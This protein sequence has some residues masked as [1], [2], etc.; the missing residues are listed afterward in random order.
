MRKQYI[1]SGNKKFYQELS[2]KSKKIGKVMNFRQN[3]WSKPHIGLNTEV[4]SEAENKIQENVS[5]S[6][7][8]NLS[9]EFE[10]DG[11][12]KPWQRPDLLKNKRKKFCDKL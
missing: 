12:K 5:K 3:D 10:E 4:R 6:L 9:G 1:E 2:M 8:D 7:N 11:R